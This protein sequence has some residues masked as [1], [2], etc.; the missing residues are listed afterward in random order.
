MSRVCNLTGKR[1]MSGHS[2]SHANNK[3]KRKF[4]VN[5]RSVSLQSTI[6]KANFRMK[7]AAST[8]RTVI[9]NGGF[10]RFIIKSDNSK[11][12]ENALKIKRKILRK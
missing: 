6:L 3:T 2:V 7:I 1:F 10:D 11:L 12:S 4:N 9:K 5:L 8:M